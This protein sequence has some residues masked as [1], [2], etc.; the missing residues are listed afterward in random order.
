[1]SGAGLFMALPIATWEFSVGVY[2]LVKGFRAP[3]ADVIEP[4]I[5]VTG[6]E[7]AVLTHA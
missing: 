3:A 1:V 4:S 6:L 7:P 5:D 2:M